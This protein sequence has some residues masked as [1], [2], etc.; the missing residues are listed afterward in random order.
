MKITLNENSK[1]KTVYVYCSPIKGSV[2]VVYIDEETGREIKT[3]EIKDLPLGEH[4]IVIDTPSQYQIS[5]I[6]EEK[7][8]EESVKIETE[9]KFDINSFAKGLGLQIGKGDKDE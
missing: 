9:Q 2:K 8:K 7:K 1:D 4:E 3:N 6:E 5:H